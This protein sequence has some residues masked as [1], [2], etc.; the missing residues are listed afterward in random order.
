MR[1]FVAKAWSSKCSW[2]K[3]M[4]GLSSLRIDLGSSKL[5]ILGVHVPSYFCILRRSSRKSSLHPCCALE[6]ALFWLCPWI[7]RTVSCIHHWITFLLNYFLLGPVTIVTSF[8]WQRI[9]HKM[10]AVYPSLGRPPTSLGTMQATFSHA[11][12]TCYWQDM[13][14]STRLLLCRISY[15]LKQ[16]VQCTLSLFFAVTL[17]EIVANDSHEWFLANYP[18]S[19]FMASCI[20]WSFFFFLVPRPSHCL[21]L[22]TCSMH[23][24]S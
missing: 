5:N 14:S 18:G 4:Y 10:C 7:T 11:A 23:T 21:V 24:V 17:S 12:S 8:S 15:R 1:K 22:I 20:G 13:T 2:F 6:S 9:P 16:T 19:A 3:A